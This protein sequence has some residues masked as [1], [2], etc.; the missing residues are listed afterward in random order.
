MEGTGGCLSLLTG[1]TNGVINLE[2]VENGDSQEGHQGANHPDDEALPR[3]CDGTRGCNEKSFHVLKSVLNSN[4]NFVL[5][6]HINFLR[7][8]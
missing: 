7:V 3:V 5:M 4:I 2:L 1:L 8:H 6:S